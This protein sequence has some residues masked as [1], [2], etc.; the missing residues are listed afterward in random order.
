M[1]T[2]GLVLSM[3]PQW[4]LDFYHSLGAFLVELQFHTEQHFHPHLPDYLL[5]Y[6]L[7]SAPGA[8]TFFASVRPLIA[9][10]E[11]HHREL[12]FE[13]LYRSGVYYVFG[14]TDTERGNGPLMSVLY[15]NPLD[16]FLRYD[17][18]LM[19]AV[20]PEAQAAYTPVSYWWLIIGAPF[21]DEAL[22]HRYLMAKID[23]YNVPR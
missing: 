2:T 8:A 15:G 22:S 13:P 3:M 20:T 11:P 21:M 16:P 7:R 10:L 4:E 6:C 5:L 1:R 12:L 9:E 23:G 19:V 18:D 14:N 17:Q